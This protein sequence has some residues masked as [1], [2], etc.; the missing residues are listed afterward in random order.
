MTSK[1]HITQLVD[2]AVE[3]GKE[4]TLKKNDDPQKEKFSYQKTVHQDNFKTGV[5]F[6]WLLKLFCKFHDLKYHFTLCVTV[7]FQPLVQ[8]SY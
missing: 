7:N 3:K 6:L 1:E 5:I 4:L 8:F 2:E